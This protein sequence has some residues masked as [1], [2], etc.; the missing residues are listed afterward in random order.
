MRTNY[1]NLWMLAAILFCGL[2]MTSCDDVLDVIDNPTTTET[3]QA[4]AQDPGIWWIDENNMDK[5]VKPGDNFFMYC[6]GTWW[7]NT[8][9]NPLYNITTRLSLMKPTFAQ[10]ANSLTDANYDIYKSHL[11][12]A[13]PNS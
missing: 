7:K 4:L 3:E 9:V 2:A 11:K 6:N 8:S 1:K 10:K 12:W 13:D 5:S